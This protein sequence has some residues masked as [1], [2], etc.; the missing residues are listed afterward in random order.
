MLVND[1]IEIIAYYTVPDV[2]YH[3]ITL[4]AAIASRHVYNTT[5]ESLWCHK[6]QVE[7]SGLVFNRS[8][9]YDQHSSYHLYYRLIN[10]R[11]YGRVTVG[12]IT[13]D[14]DGATNVAVNGRCK[15]G[16]IVVSTNDALIIYTKRLDVWIRHTTLDIRG[17]ISIRSPTGKYWCRLC[18]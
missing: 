17:V 15:T 9:I 3:L 6:V 5:A 14:V 1:L 2:T 12:G 18:L 7:R 11:E 13:L 10:K 16:E 8:V 4:G